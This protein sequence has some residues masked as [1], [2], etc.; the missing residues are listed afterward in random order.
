MSQ[1]D[2]KTDEARLDAL[3]RRMAENS[4]GGHWQPREPKPELK[5]FLW[6]W[7]VIYSCLMESGEVV[8][9]G[10]VDEA[11]K[12][13]TVQLVN[14]GIAAQKATSRTLQMS[15]QLVKPGERAECHRHTPAALRFVVE[16]DGRGYTTVEGERMLMEP[17]DLILTPNWTWH[18]HYN[19]GDKPMIWLDV[20]DIHLVNHLDANFQE[21]YGEGPAQPVTRPDG[22]CRQR[23][24]AIRPRAGKVGGGALP[25]TYKW[26][27]ALKALNELSAAGA[28][29]PHDGILL[30][31]ANPLTGGPTL[32]TIGCWIQMLRPG[33]ETRPHRH[34]SSTIYHVVQGEGVTTVG[35]KKGAGEDLGWET[36][37]C[38]FVPSSKWHRFKNRSRKEPAI[39]FSVTDRP[40]LESL[41]LYRHEGE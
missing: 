13:R 7:P 39:I 26:R 32:P 21:N 18:D 2:S 19:P 14:P 30:E 28:A 37:D 35:E 27:D 11:A 31:Y 40:V 1:V 5:P 8:R 41:G 22:Y 6:R 10:H 23:L 12:R 36:R 25:Y 24:G 17:G 33:E 15:V 16:A 29:D 20:L 4:L 34:T 3:H 38:F 9:L